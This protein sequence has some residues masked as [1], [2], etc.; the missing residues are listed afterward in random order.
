MIPITYGLPVDVGIFAS[1]LVGERAQSAARGF[2]DIQF[3]NTVTWIGA[4]QV[5]NWNSQTGIGPEN[6]DF[7]LAAA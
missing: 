7:T 4:G 1:V 6:T 3:Q 2:A 5:F